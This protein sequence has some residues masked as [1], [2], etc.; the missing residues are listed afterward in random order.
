MR[1]STSG[2]TEQACEQERGSQPGSARMRMC[3]CLC[4]WQLWSC[5]CFSRTNLS[6]RYKATWIDFLPRPEKRQGKP[7]TKIKP[8]CP[9]NMWYHSRTIKIHL[10]ASW[11]N[12]GS[13]KE[14]P[15]TTSLQIL[16]Q[17]QR[18]SVHDDQDKYEHPRSCIT[19]NKPQEARQ[20]A[21]KM[22]ESCMKIQEM[23]F[24]TF[25]N[26]QML[27]SVRFSSPVRRVITNFMIQYWIVLGRRACFGILLSEKNV[28]FVYTH[29]HA[30]AALHARTYKY[31]HVRTKTHSAST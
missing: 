16:T 18:A 28:H 17:H 21:F 26:I 24:L 19:P 14:D 9:H 22:K 8:A 13:H 15:R 11:K 5:R 25:I 30:H 4:V 31:A 3:V 27:V 1:V 2:R 29:A 12:K 7:H 23:N 20:Q 6:D 10:R